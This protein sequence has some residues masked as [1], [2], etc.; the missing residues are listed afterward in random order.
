[1]KKKTLKKLKDGA[2]FKFNLRSKVEWSL[3]TKYK[4]DEWQYAIV[5]A[6]VSGITKHINSLH[7][8]YPVS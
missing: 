1:M 4:Y 2:K 8:V 5:T 6:V 7:E 3:Q